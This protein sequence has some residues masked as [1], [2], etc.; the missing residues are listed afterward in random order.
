MTLTEVYRK[1]E[2]MLTEA[3]IPDSDVD[4]AVLMEHFF[5]CDRARLII[6][7]D[8]KADEGLTQRYFDAITERTTG[9][10]L[11]YITGIW[12]FMGY[13]FY[14]GEGVLIP[15]DDTEILAEEVC[16][17]LYGKKNTSA[18]DLCSGSGAIAITLGKVRPDCT[19]L[20][21][22][23]SKDALGY[24]DR[25]IELNNT[26][27]VTAV[28]GDV[29]ECFG[30]YNDGTFD[31]VVSNPPYIESEEIDTLQQELKFE[32]RMA[33]DGGKDG[34]Y[35]YRI[36]TDKWK[37]KIKPGGM[38]AFE[39]GERQSEPVSELLRIHGF[40]NIYTKTDLH[41]YN[42]IVCGIKNNR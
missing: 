2:E 29:T 24:L 28:C 27:N 34:L 6:H 33:L 40:E 39:V 15:R 38:L 25:N 32:P 17:F 14:V 1:G 10:P 11:Q 5:G 7:G 30:D 4:A 26:A 22:E 20:A 9:R 8:D 36:I 16:T 3:N 23:Y 42:R 12:N 18:I 41:G 21:V 13:D 35:F 37:S 19:V 31:L